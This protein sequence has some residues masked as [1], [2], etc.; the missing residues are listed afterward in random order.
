MYSWYLVTFVFPITLVTDSVFLSCREGSRLLLRDTPVPS[1]QHRPA[2]VPLPTFLPLWLG[3]LSRRESLSLVMRSDYFP[4]GH[5]ECKL[6]PQ[7]SCTLPGHHW[8][9]VLPTQGPLPG[10]CQWSLLSQAFA[11]CLEAEP[12]ET[13]WAMLLGPCSVTLFLLQGAGTLRSPTV[14]CP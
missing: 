2:V 14:P 9:G 11:R 5:Q 13:L 4:C 6:C 10:L 7:H 12:T 3:I 1:Q 8:A